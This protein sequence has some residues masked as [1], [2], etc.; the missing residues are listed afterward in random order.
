MRFILPSLE[1]PLSREGSYWML[2]RIN[3]VGPS[4]AHPS[5]ILHP[6]TLKKKKSD[7]ARLI[8]DYCCHSAKKPRY[9]V[10]S[11]VTFTKRSPWHG[12]PTALIPHEGPWTMVHRSTWWRTLQKHKTQMTS[13]VT[14]QEQL[15]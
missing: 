2:A 5:L 4:T 13:R 15:L 1:I 6:R 12:C 7:V 8:L 11:R 9:S 14:Q 3:P 10:L